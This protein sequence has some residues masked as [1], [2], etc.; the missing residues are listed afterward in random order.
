MIEQPLTLFPDPVAEPEL[1]VPYTHPL[2]TLSQRA[3]PEID[4]KQNDPLRVGIPA[5]DPLPVESRGARTPRDMPSASPSF[6]RSMCGKPWASML[7]LA[8]RAS[9]RSIARSAP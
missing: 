9:R 6:R 8:S 3:R 2:F 1:S 5:A 7:R 4:V